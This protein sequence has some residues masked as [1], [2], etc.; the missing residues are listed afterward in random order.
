MAWDLVMWISWQ[1][2]TWISWQGCLTVTFGGLCIRRA[3]C[4]VK[5]GVFAV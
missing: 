5:D 2:V 1:F 4:I 3:R